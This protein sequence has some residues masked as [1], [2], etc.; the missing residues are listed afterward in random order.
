MWLLIEPRISLSAGPSLT[1]RPLNAGP[2]FL[3]STVSQVQLDEVLVMY[4]QFRRQLLE[5]VHR[6]AIEPNGDLTL[7]LLRVGILMR[8]GKIVLFRHRILQYTSSSCA[9]RVA[10]VPHETSGL[11]ANFSRTFRVIVETASSTNSAATQVI[12]PT[13]NTAPPWSR[14]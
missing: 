3:E 9:V 11:P 13:E 1:P 14:S 8:L 5:I 10:N 12:D 4:L 2:A 6:G 7:E